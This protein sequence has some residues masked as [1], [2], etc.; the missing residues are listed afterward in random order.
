MQCPYCT[1]EIN[2]AAV[3]CPVCTR[4]LYLIKPLLD[5]I[6]GL[7]EKIEPDSV[8]VTYLKTPA[9]DLTPR[10]KSGIKAD[11]IDVA[12]ASLPPGEHQIRVTVK[13]SEGRETNS[14]L[15]ISV[16]Q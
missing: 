4:D 1:S 12:K 3:V 2:D 5:K 14:T 16:A 13:D 9:V 15:N 7:E 11:G 8:K 6:A 10:V